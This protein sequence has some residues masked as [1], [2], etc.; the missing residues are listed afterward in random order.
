[1]GNETFYGDGRRGFPLIGKRPIWRIHPVN[2]DPLL[3]WAKFGRID[4]H[5]HNPRTTHCS[6]LIIREKKDNSNNK[7]PLVITH[8][9]WRELNNKIQ[10]NFNS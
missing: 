10:K 7:L 4:H 2:L 3:V 1:M 6:S 8:R 9:N 5:D